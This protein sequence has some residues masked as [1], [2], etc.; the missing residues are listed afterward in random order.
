MPPGEAASSIIPTASTGGSRNSSTSPKQRAGS[1]TSWQ[2][3]AMIT[4]FGCFATRPK[5]ES[6]SESPSPSMM[7]PSATGSPMVVNADPMGTGWQSR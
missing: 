5:S 7:M 2:S 1:S 6:R 3:R 4:A